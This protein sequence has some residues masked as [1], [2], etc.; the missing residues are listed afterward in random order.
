MF[1]P[2][3]SSA[4]S[5]MIDDAAPAVTRSD[6]FTHPMTESHHQNNEKS[7]PFRQPQNK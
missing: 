5:V 3:D 2:N 7:E 4:K 6:H 1:P